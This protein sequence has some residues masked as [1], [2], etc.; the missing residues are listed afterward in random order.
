[1]NLTRE[2][3]TVLLVLTADWLTP[4]QIADQLPDESGDLASVNQALKDLILAGLVQTN[5]VV[6]GLYRLTAE[7]IDVQELEVGINEN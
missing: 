6:F 3:R 2:Q 7:G 4:K 5:P 1:M